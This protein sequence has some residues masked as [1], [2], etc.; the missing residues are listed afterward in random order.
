MSASNISAMSG[1]ICLLLLM[2][3]LNPTPGNEGMTR[4]KGRSL[5]GS[6][7]V[8]KMLMRCVKER[9][10]NGKGGIRSNGTAPACVDRE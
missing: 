7:G 8:V 1:S 2:A 9:F 3:S 6:S 4:W 5:E 10:V